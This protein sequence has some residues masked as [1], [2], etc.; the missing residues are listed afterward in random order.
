MDKA[1]EVG[2]TFHGARVNKFKN[3]VSMEVNEGIT[4][5]FDLTT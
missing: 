5:R 1:E 2:K 3:G 4:S